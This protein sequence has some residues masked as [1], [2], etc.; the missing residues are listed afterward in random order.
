MAKKKE[1][2]PATWDEELAQQAQAA[3]AM[4]SNTS[5]GQCFSLRGGIL[6]WNDMPIPDNRLA[7]IIVDSILE[8]VYYDGP[9]DPDEPQAPCCF[10]FGRD[11]TE[12]TPHEL[13]VAAKSNEHDFCSGCPM[14]EWGSASIGRGKACR[15]VRRL[16]LI[17]AGE[18]KDGKFNIFDDLEQF[19]TAVIG[20][21]KIPVTSVKGYSAFVKQIAGAMQLPPHGVISCI[22][23]VPDNKSQ[24]KVMFSVI[25][26]VPGELI[27]TIIK[28][29]KEA[30]TLIEFPYT[31]NDGSEKDEPKPKVKKNQKRKY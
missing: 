18:F 9:Y 10:A 21:L 19:E 6:S 31:L 11:E 13:V 12:M 3:A 16:A 20:Y 5:T 8:N 25:Q 1:N 27:G 22:Q 15:N 23:V 14:N 26:P 28:R 24:F 17:P 4:E 30:Q 7:V 29:H 2:L